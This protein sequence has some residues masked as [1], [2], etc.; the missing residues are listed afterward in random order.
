[1]V[2][3]PTETVHAESA[4]L[5]RCNPSLGLRN[6]FDVTPDEI[7]EL[8]DSDLRELV[9]LLCEAE[10]EQ[11]GLSPS[12]VTYGGNQNAPDG[13]IDVRVALPPGSEIG[14]FVPR[15]L[16]GFQVKKP[17]MTRAEIIREMR[18]D[19]QIRPSIQNLANEA[20][21][22]VIVSS[23]ASTSD[24]E[25]QERRTDGMREA[26]ADIENP[27][28]LETEF[29]DRTRLATWVR[30]HPGYIA[31]VK[32]KIGRAFSGWRPYGPWSGTA[33]DMDAEYLLDDKLRLH[34]GQRGEPRPVSD[35]LDELRDTL[36][37]PGKVVRLV[38]LSG[39]GKTRLVQA[40]FDDRVGERPLA[41]ALAVYANMNDNP[42]PQPTGLA[43]DLLA[44]GAR[45]ILIVDNCTPDLHG[46]LTDLCRGGDSTISLLTVEYDIRDDQPEGTEVVRL[47][48]SSTELIENLVRRRYPHLSQVD[49]STIAEA[50]GG[51]ARIAIAL[52]ET[53]EQTESIAGIS[54]DDLF[55]RLFRQRNETN[56][57]LLLAAQACSL[58]YSFDVETMLGD[59]AE[60]MRLGEIAELGP[61]AMYRHVR[62]LLRRDLV[63]ERGVWRAVLPHAIANRLAAR[64]LEDTPYEFIHQKILESGNDR[65]ARSFSRRIMFLHDHPQAVAV[66]ERWLAPEGLLGDVASLDDMKRAIFENVAPVLP[67]RALEALERVADGAPEGASQVLRR[68]TALLRS[69]AYDPDLFDRSVRILSRIALDVDDEHDEKEATE[70]FVSLFG[71][72]LS[73]THA[74]IEQRLRVIDDLLRSQDESAWALGLSALDAALEAS[75]FGSVF[76][77]E[78]GARSRDYGFEPHSVEEASHWYSA[79]LEMIERLAFDENIHNERLRET[80][81]G[82]LRGLWSSACP[83]DQLDHL[84]RRF[85]GNGFWRRGW[86]ACRASLRYDTNR[87][88]PDLI[89]CISTLEEAL[90]PTNLCEQV[91]AIVLG[92]DYHDFDLG[93]DDPEDDGT[94][95]HERVVRR[96]Q[97]LGESVALDQ[98][99]FAEL[100]PDLLRGGE[101][102]WPFGRGLAGAVPDPRN[103]W[104]S[105][106]E[107]LNDVPGP[108][109]DVRVILG[110]LEGV[111]ERDGEL[112]EE[113]LDQA[114]DQPALVPFLPSLHMAVQLNERG[115]ER[116]TGALTSGQVPVGKFAILAGGR[117]TDQVDGGILRDFLFLIA[118]QPDG[119][120]VAIHILQMRFFSDRSEH[121]AYDPEL[122]FAGQELLRRAIFNRDQ[123]RR[124]RHLGE[125]AAICLRDADCGPLAGE[126]AGRLR[127]AVAAYE[128]YAIQ[129][130][131]L[132]RAMLETQPVRVLD[133]LLIGDDAEVRAGQKLFKDVGRHGN[134]PARII[135]DPVFV[136]WCEADP[137]AR[138]PIA[139]SIVPLSGRSEETGMPIW[140]EAAQ[141]LIRGARDPQRVLEV[142]ISRFRPSGGDGSLAAI[143]ESN[144]HLFEQLEALVSPE[145]LPFIVEAKARFAEEI[146][147]MRSWETEID[148]GRDERFE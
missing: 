58:V 125:V 61:V 93:D 4:I 71:L 142:L 119:W 116:L 73:G 28:Q 121:R 123:Q 140:T 86:L 81:A 108:E 88:P 120:D 112:L 78:F 2:D 69:L 46:R 63:Q 101:R 60:L 102:V 127:Q 126:I 38:G 106:L 95:G 18:P 30:R 105:F 12:A 99:V 128:T 100:L 70:A 23:G 48:T 39:V 29:Y 135:S 117:A 136:E 137:S 31:W 110:F 91:R 3:R 107:R 45:A 64:A 62:E 129:N 21:A 67:V 27:D 145:L 49:A 55:Q 57:A 122:I 34:L 131:G 25:L 43:S 19:N 80:L 124:D 76:Q 9:G 33:E 8:N 5:L 11:R 89:A 32:E 143:M 74:T 113:F 24:T 40:L 44:K 42:D 16:T 75:D 144:A 66:V 114:V 94:M 22:Y 59:G 53:V 20:G 111:K 138:Y 84:A 132:L 85:A 83:P 47:D 51:N 68:H 41:P 77:F 97:E 65:L 134:N 54:D 115:V 103:T 104:N 90:R 14:G 130:D 50:S 35:A 56:D 72:Y 36:A 82:N 13:G 141:A 133:A 146:E 6:M 37:E 139:A 52:A 147:R 96:S 1:M 26:L 109:R 118:D 17:N 98:P 15:S 7:A 10:L 87:M 148:R 79:A 92:I